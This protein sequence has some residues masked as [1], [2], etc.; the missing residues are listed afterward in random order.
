MTLTKMGGINN[1]WLLKVKF[2]HNRA[3]DSDMIRQKVY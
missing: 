2:E 3:W 1:G